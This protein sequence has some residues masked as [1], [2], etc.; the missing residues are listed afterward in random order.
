MT[1]VV[2]VHHDDYAD[3]VFECLMINSGRHGLHAMGSA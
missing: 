2:L 3:W 1:A